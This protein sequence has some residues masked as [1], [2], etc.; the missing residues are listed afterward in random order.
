MKIGVDAGALAITDDRLKVGVWRVT[1]ELLKALTKLDT[2]NDYCL[3]SFRPIERE[4]ISSFGDNVRNVVVRPAKG[5]M[6]IALPAYLATHNVN[7]FLG[8]SQTL[9]SFGTSYNLGFVYDLKFLHKPEAYRD[10]FHSLSSQTKDLI[11]KSDQIIT[12][13]NSSKLDIVKTYG[14]KPEK[15]IV[16]YPGVSNVFNISGKVKKI[17]NGFIL[18]VGA[19]KPGKGVP[20][21]L[22]AFKKFISKTKRNYTFVLVGGDFWP[23]PAIEKTIKDLNLVRHIRMTGRISDDELATYYRGAVALIVPSEWEGFCLPAAEAIVSGCPVVGLDSGSLPEV[24]REGGL[25]VNPD[26]DNLANALERV[27]AK[28]FRK[29]VRERSSVAAQTF[30]WISMAT[31]LLSAYPRL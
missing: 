18:Y 24:V 4:I 15:V 20:L 14:L 2:S 10:S 16:C 23:D 26:A 25:L 19:L 11:R 29:T 9:P 8:M 7:I 5:W 13:S 31:C 22:Q 27:I 17:D 1:F 30:S 6:K 12:I 21:A 28:E 3:F